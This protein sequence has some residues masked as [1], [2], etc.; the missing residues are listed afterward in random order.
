MNDY[1]N[2]N[3]ENNNPQN[4][5][6]NDAQ[7]AGN[8]H[9]TEQGYEHQAQP[10]TPTPPPAAQQTSYP[11]QPSQENA[12]YYYTPS[13]P[14]N[15]NSGQNPGQWN[16]SQYT[17]PGGNKP[18]KRNR[19]LVVFTV[20]LC[21]VLLVGVLF[22]AGIGIY[23]VL[24][25]SSG[26]IQSLTPT[27]D[28]SNSAGGGDVQLPGLE[29]QDKPIEEENIVISDDGRLSTPE[30]AR[31]VTPVVV[32]VFQYGSYQGQ[33]YS[34]S[35]SGIIISED[36]YIATNA[37]VVTLPDGTA[38][39]SFEV[40]LSDGTRKEAWLVGFDS[41]TDLAVLKIDAENLAYAQFGN[42]DQL[43]IGETVI[44][45]GYPG[46]EDLS[47]SLSQGVV[48]GLDREVKTSSEGY[49]INCLQ[50]DAAINPGNS[51]GPLLNQYGQVIGINTSKLVDTEFE[52]IG[53][54]I[55]INDAVPIIDQLIEHGR[56]VD[57]ARLGIT[58][59]S[60]S[61]NYSQYYQLPQGIMIMSTDPDAD[62]STLG[63]RTGEVAGD[64]I[65]AV[66][67][68]SVADFDDVANALD[69][70]VPGDQ[71]TLSIYRMEYRGE[72][73]STF[74]VTVTLLA[75]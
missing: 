22:L 74:D 41:R 24:G 27:P 58:G 10:N 34:G 56:V 7:N 73:E 21:S 33:M 3:Q 71:V 36:G 23:S 13:Q 69:D 50:T 2:N 65:T 70:K 75:E 43:E 64:I 26:S 32:G 68:Q 57:R 14:G 60:I 38:S 37:H 31:R 48:S 19:G 45:I 61:M 8:Q 67:G 16:Y 44:A 72:P 47:N 62:I 51:G 29:L 9:P 59:V 52:G 17:A 18:P 63:L 66:D 40:V 28:T 54:S 5:Q 12:P 30:I 42:S 39:D 46:G 4:D 20:L 11:Q 35:G 49:S 1:P 15:N 55:P 6:Q 25:T 53:F